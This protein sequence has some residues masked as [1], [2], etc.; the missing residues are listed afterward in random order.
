MPTHAF[1]ISKL[2]DAAGVNVE[3]IRYY[4]RRGLLEEPTRVANGFRAY[5]AEHLQRLLF[6]KRAAALG[7]SLDDT[8]ELASVSRTADR[9]RLR[10]MART[11]AADIR[12]R[13]TQLE[14]MANALEHL[15]ANC[16]HTAPDAPCPIVAALHAD[17]AEG[18]SPA[19][20][21]DP[22]RTVSDKR[23]TKRSE[24]DLTKR[25]GTRRS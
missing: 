8:A 4:Q 23:L 7:F 20:P 12:Q 2:A 22:G 1:T 19:A 10:T 24:K 5:T 15:A 3:T 9:K 13:I 16:H 21:A 6:I 17:P 14:A 11:R 25:S 18:E